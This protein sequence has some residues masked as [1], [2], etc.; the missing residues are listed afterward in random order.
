LGGNWVSV[1]VKVPGVRFAKVRLSLFWALFVLS[2]KLPMP[3]LP[4]KVKIPLALT[5]IFSMTTVPF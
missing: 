1:T 5:E 3:L 4:V 2:E